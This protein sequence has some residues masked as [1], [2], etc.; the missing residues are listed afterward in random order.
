MNPNLNNLKIPNNKESH[1][2]ND[3]NFSSV[4]SNPNLFNLH[5]NIGDVPIIEVEE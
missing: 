1:P 4:N 3:Q 5:D 2:N